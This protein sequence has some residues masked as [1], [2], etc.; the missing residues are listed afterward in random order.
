MIKLYKL[1]LENDM[2]ANLEVTDNTISLTSPSDPGKNYLYGWKYEDDKYWLKQL[3]WG[4]QEDFIP[5]NQ[6]VWDVLEPSKGRVVVNVIEILRD[7]RNEQAEQGLGI[8]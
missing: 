2:E 7:F 3:N 8:K 4:T 5:P 6:L 1:I